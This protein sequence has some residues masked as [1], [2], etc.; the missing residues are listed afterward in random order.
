MLALSISDFPLHVC[1]LLNYFIG[2]W[3]SYI[4]DTGSS[5]SLPAH[6]PIKNNYGFYYHCPHTYVLQAWAH[7][8]NHLLKMILMGKH[9]VHNQQFVRQVGRFPS[10]SPLLRDSKITFLL[11]YHRATQSTVMVYPPLKSE[12][13]LSAE[14]ASMG[15]W[16]AS[17]SQWIIFL[18]TYTSPISWLNFIVY[19]MGFISCFKNLKSSNQR[20]GSLTDGSKTLCAEWFPSSGIPGPLL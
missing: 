15:C 20:W 19:K 10:S 2:L 6:F 3:N 18:S 12:L 11:F 16:V 7:W 4:T 5:K 8:S 9:H 1:R 14:T 13:V 17:V